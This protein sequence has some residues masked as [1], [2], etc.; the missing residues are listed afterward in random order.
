MKDGQKDDRQKQPGRLMRQTGR[1][2]E[3]RP[4]KT[5]GKR[6]TGRRPTKTVGKT[7]ETDRQKKNSR[8]D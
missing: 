3:R 7:D 4:T 2:T 1:G 6:E 8:E 5:V